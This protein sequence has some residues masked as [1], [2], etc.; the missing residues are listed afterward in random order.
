MGMKILMSLLIIL[1]VS[2]LI[3]YY[4]TKIRKFRFL[5]N[6]WGALVIGLAG[7]ILMNYSLVSLIKFFEEG[8][9]INI[10]SVFF[11]AYFFIKIF[12]KITP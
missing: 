1:L 5:G 8:F 6:F 9:N 11:G 10:L 3:A 7:G 2:G 12:H 4:Y